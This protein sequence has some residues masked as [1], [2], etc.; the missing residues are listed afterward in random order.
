MFDQWKNNTYYVSYYVYNNL[1]LL[2]NNAWTL[3]QSRDL[4]RKCFSFKIFNQID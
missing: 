1:K 3:I 4:I 2:I